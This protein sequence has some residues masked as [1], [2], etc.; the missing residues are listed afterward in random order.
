VAGIVS[1]PVPA[2]ANAGRCNRA[3]AVSRR[4]EVKRVTV[5]GGT[6]DVVGEQKTKEIVHV[7]G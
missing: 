2:T 6:D 1:L 4:G 7:F 3:L 5:F